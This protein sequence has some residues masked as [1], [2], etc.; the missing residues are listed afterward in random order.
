MRC[1]ERFAVGRMVCVLGVLLAVPGLSDVLRSP[2]RGE[3]RPRHLDSTMPRSELAPCAAEWVAPVEVAATASRLGAWPGPGMRLVLRGGAGGERHRKKHKGKG[4]EMQRGEESEDSVG[5][6]DSEMG[7]EYEDDDEVNGAS[8]E[9][10]DA[11]DA[12]ESSVESWYNFSSSG[13]SDIDAGWHDEG[14][15][16]E[17]RLRPAP[18]RTQST[19]SA[20]AP[21]AAL[22]RGACGSSAG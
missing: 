20:C 9:K 5:E 7:A 2:A 1:K 10:A 14:N 15:D 4:K 19:T 21:R 17:V 13:G 11:G 12:L 18:Q 22:R 8:A 16:P 3:L 6:E